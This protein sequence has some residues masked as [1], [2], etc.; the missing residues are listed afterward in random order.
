LLAEAADDEP[1]PVGRVVSRTGSTWQGDWASSFSWLRRD[2]PFAGLPGGPMLDMSFLP[3]MPAAVIAGLPAWLMREHSWAGLA[4]GWLHKHVSLLA[5][6]RHGEGHMV[7][8]TFRLQPDVLAA[9]AVAQTL[10]A[11]ILDLLTD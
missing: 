2:G 11:A 10:F 9:D 6:M 8:T 1:L 7:V 3:V 4:A 5:T